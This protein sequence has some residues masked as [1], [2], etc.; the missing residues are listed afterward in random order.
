MDTM[1]DK[2]VLA[3]VEKANSRSPAVAGDMIGA[4]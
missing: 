2:G 1:A 3:E 4:W